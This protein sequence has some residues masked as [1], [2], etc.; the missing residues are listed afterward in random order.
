MPHVSV[1]FDG[2]DEPETFHLAVTDSSQEIIG[3]S[4][5]MMRPFHSG[6]LVPS[7]QLRGMAT[8]SR[9]Q[10]RGIGGLLL[11]HGIAHAETRDVDA[12]WANARD[13]ALGFYCSHGFE[14]VGEG[15]IESATRL[16]HHRV[17]RLV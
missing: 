9:F 6:S 2:D 8:S 7:I 15:F 16:P 10:G 3:V 14:I 5:W 17:R 11:E 1:D 13:S 4:T 12:V